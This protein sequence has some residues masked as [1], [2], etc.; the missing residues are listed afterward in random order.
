MVTVKDQLFPGF[1]G[2]EMNRQSRE[3]VSLGLNCI[4]LG[5]PRWLRW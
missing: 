5:L 2:G 3:D 1:G 4:F